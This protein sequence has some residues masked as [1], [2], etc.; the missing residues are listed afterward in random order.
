MSL[1][2]EHS[3]HLKLNVSRVLQCYRGVT[4]V[5]QGCFKADQRVLKGCSKLVLMGVPRV[6]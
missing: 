4:L 2:L 3:T 1:G 6:F 5:L